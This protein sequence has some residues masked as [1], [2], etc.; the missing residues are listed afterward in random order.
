MLNSLKMNIDIRFNRK[1]TKEDYV[2]PGEY[3]MV[4]FGRSVKFDFQD[5]CGTI[6]NDDP[7]VL[8]CQLKHPDF[9]AFEDFCTI[10]DAE[11]QNISEIIECYVYIG[12]EC[13]PLL[14]EVEILS[15]TFLLDNGYIAEISEAVIQKY[16]SAL[17]KGEN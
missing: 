7:T 11:L 1:L 13:N 6:D 17:M 2:I 3:E 12:E 14:R 9:G 15:I 5:Y 8:H 16:N 10:M 4:F